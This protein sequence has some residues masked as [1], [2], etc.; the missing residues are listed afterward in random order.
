MTPEFPSPAPT[1]GSVAAVSLGPSPTGWEETPGLGRSKAPSDGQHEE[2]SRGC[3]EVGIDRDQ[4]EGWHREWA[5]LMLF[6]W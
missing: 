1:V 6:G 2:E 3:R 4:A 5:G